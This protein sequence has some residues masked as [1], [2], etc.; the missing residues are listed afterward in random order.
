M[1]QWLCNLLQLHNVF[2]LLESY[3][4]RL[5]LF[6]WGRRSHR[7]QF[8]SLKPLMSSRVLRFRRPTQYFWYSF[9][10]ITRDF[11][12]KINIIASKS[13]RNHK[14]NSNSTSSIQIN[15]NIVFFSN[16]ATITRKRAKKITDSL[17]ILSATLCPTLSLSPKM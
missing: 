9:S 16:N 3:L 8:E 14:H 5:V 6:K 11:R 17:L 7:T 13:N 4:S 2:V 1:F 10:S 12:K 15:V